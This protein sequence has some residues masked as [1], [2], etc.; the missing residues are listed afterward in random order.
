MLPGATLDVKDLS[1]PFI[2]NRTH[3]LKKQK[4]TIG[5][6]CKTYTYIPRFTRNL[7]PFQ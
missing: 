6:H 1:N 2:R 7:R 4:K 3:K 5:H